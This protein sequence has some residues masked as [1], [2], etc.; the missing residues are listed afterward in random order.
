MAIDRSAKRRVDLPAKPSRLGNTPHDG[1]ARGS[2]S[3]RTK[4]REKQHGQRSMSF[5][6]EMALAKEASEAG[7]ISQV[8]MASLASLSSKVSS[9]G[10]PSRLDT[11]FVADERFLSEELDDFDASMPSIKSEALSPVKSQPPSTVN[12][13]PP[14]PLE[15]QPL[16]SQG[17][18]KNGPDVDD[19]KELQPPT[20]FD[21]SPFPSQPTEGYDSDEDGDQGQ[22]H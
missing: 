21:F 3:S 11:S 8:K 9:A 4:I 17:L 15:L 20:V 6:G 22:P 1:K 19:G 5:D 7:R 16:P 10:V 14:A 2:S 12:P 13:A 18:A